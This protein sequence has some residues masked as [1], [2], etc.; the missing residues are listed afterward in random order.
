MKTIEDFNFNNK[1]ALIR[2]DFNVPLDGEYKVTDTT[3]IEAAKPTILKILKDGGSAI[4][5]SHLGRPKGQRSN[6][7]SL[8][9]IVAKVSEILRSEERRVGKGWR[10]GMGMCG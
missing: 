10:T 8:K 1:K 9:H 7:L 3:R 5:M 6:E 4:L 2:V